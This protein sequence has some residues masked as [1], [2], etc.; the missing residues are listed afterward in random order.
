MASKDIGRVSRHSGDASAEKERSKRDSGAF[1][2][3]AKLEMK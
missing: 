1:T 3:M 2:K